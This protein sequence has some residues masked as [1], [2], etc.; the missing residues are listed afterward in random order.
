MKQDFSLSALKAFEARMFA[1]EVYD[2]S[3]D[4]KQYLNQLIYIFFNFLQFSGYY[5]PVNTLYF[6]HTFCLC[7][8]YQKQ[9]WLCLQTALT[10]W[11][12]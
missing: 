1:P 10:G 4:V 5:I 9:K 7:F 2:K 6:T 11:S 8:D 3:Q 12:L